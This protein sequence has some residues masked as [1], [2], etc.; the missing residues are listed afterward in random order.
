M[1]LK[2]VGTTS[3]SDIDQTMAI[4]P[5]E[6]KC[7]IWPYLPVSPSPGYL[8]T[9]GSGCYSGATTSILGMEYISGIDVFRLDGPKAID[10]DHYLAKP[11]GGYVY[12]I[13]K[14]PPEIVPYHHL[15]IT[16][17]ILNYVDLGWRP[18]LEKVLRGN[19]N[20]YLLG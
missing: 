8:F 18:F 4:D 15:Q 13:F 10:V 17:P 7:L 14:E 11:F 9:T 16:D 12:G 20:Y 5:W 1:E 2:F 6:S 19:I 3:K